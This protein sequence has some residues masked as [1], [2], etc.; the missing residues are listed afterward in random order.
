MSNFSVHRCAAIIFKLVS[1]KRGGPN[2]K[3]NDRL[4]KDEQYLTTINEEIEDHL[5]NKNHE[6]KM[7]KLEMLKAKIKSSTIAYSINKNRKNVNT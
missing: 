5:I 3:F 6:S 7:I 1:F 2:W 4:L